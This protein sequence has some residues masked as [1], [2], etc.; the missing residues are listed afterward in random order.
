MGIIHT[1][2]AII[3]IVFISGFVGGFVLSI[4]ANKWFL[5]DKDGN[6]F[7][8]IFACII[9][10]AIALIIFAFILHTCKGGEGE[11]IPTNF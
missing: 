7:V 10:G 2:I 3:G 5:N 1:L 4:A 8:K 6:P 9:V 11:F